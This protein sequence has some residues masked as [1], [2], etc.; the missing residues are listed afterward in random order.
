MPNDYF[1]PGAT[2]T[3]ADRI[4]PAL[5]VVSGFGGAASSV[6]TSTGLAA[7]EVDADPELLSGRFLILQ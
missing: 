3:H 6:E 2:L 7:P 4:P 5:D 1:E